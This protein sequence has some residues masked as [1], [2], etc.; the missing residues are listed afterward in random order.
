MQARTPVTVAEKL[1][2]GSKKLFYDVYTKFEWPDKLDWTEWAMSPELVSLYG[3][4]AWDALDE[5]QRRKLAFYECGGFFSLILHGERPLLEGM[6]HRLYTT[7]KDLTV[8][9]YMHHFLDEENKHMIMF[10]TFLRRY[11]GKVYP[12]KKVA[13]AR[14]QAKGEDEIAFFA[15]V[16][17]VEELSDVYNLTMANDERLA[18][19]VRAVNHTHHMDEARHIHFGRVYLKQQWDKFT[20]AWSDAEKE[21]FRSWLVDYINASWRDFYSPY[22]YRDAGVPDPYE[23]REA[24]LA[25]PV[26]RAHRQRCS[27]KYVENLV[28]TGILTE[29]PQLQ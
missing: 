23:V 15:K 6:S 13:H 29:V 5:S 9:E 18:P 10:S 25:S 2:R 21:S 22:V 7:E 14:P 1:S 26:C 4:P 11:F 16:L 3:T 17:V 28:E 12:E 8:T 24:A 20:P 27:Q 19:I